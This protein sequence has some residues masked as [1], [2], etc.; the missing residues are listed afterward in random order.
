[1]ANDETI[2]EL[3]EREADETFASITDLDSIS[4]TT[5][6]GVTF[7]LSAIGV[8]TSFALDRFPD[9]SSAER[10]FVVLSV[11]CVGT[12]GCS[13]YYLI[14]SLFPRYFYTDN[15]GSTFLPSPFPLLNRSTAAADQFDGQTDLESSFEDWLDTY[16]GEV[17][18]EDNAE[19]QFAR[20]HNYKH[21]ARIKAKNIAYGLA[22]LRISVFLFVLV[23][24]FGLLAPYFR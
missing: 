22:W 13:L 6:V 24:A 7:L 4:D 5:V 20:F 8:W 11:L 1:M 16:H 18:V 3:A 21:V 15:V 23:I 19:F 12:I 9:G 17:V 2:S 14:G 10:L